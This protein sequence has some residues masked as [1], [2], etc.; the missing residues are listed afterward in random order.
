[1]KKI[2]IVITFVC[3][4]TL[5]HGQTSPGKI[6]VNQIE[7]FDIAKFNKGQKGGF[8]EYKDKYGNEVQESGAQ[9]SEYVYKAK[10]AKSLLFT[11]YKVYDSKTLIIQTKGT[12]LDHVAIGKW[13]YYNRDGS[14]A[15]QVDEDK[16]FGKFGAAQLLNF[17]QKQK[18][19]NLKT[20]AGREYLIS[21]DFG[22]EKLDPKSKHSWGS[23][24]KGQWSV[25]Y[26]KSM[27]FIDHTFIIDSQTGRLI[28]HKN[29]KGDE[30][31]QHPTVKQKKEEGSEK[32]DIETF[33]KHQQNGLYE[34]DMG[35]TQVSEFS[36]ADG[37][38]EEIT[39][40]DQ[41]LKL[42][43]DFYKNGTIKQKGLT[44]IKGG[45]MMGVWQFF[46]S[47]GKLVHETNYDSWY[48]FTWDDLRSF[49]REN[50]VDMQDINTN[51]SRTW[52][53][54]EKR[55]WV[56]TYKTTP[57]KNGNYIRTVTLN[58]DSGKIEKEEWAKPQRS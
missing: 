8:Y 23:P 13:I 50:H 6:A 18:L 55:V 14:I 57:N 47:S 52:K 32:F 42:T 30:L 1:M 7:K 5:I 22:T 25:T 21:V 10:L 45:F 36:Y 33:R 54:G 39:H 40:T 4:N 56:I 31:V 43:K 28:S 11:T 38:V 9:A 2:L 15:K 27:P 3:C 53:E 44:F 41:L 12:Y 19:V 51:I 37:Y 49:L 35:D 58:G 24:D 29:L 48:K 16:K 46:D 34:V 26:T 17:L 20:G